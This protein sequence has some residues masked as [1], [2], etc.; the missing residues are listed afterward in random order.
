MV[1]IFWAGI[2]KRRLSSRAR[3]R[4]DISARARAATVHGAN[5][6]HRWKQKLTVL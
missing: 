5:R 2:P 6:P 3:L 4:S 1:Q